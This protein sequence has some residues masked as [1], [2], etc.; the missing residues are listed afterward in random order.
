MNTG[1]NRYGIFILRIYVILY[2]FSKVAIRDFR[3]SKLWQIMNLLRYFD[4]AAFFLSSSSS[5]PRGYRNGIDDVTFRYVIGIDMLS[6]GDQ[7]GHRTFFFI[8]ELQ[9]F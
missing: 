9:I 4:G 5:I 8:D 2:C 6:D 1:T 7:F 3:D